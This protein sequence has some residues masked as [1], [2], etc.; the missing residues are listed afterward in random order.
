M[1]NNKLRAKSLALLATGISQTFF[2]I[3]A[4]AKI[5][6]EVTLENFQSFEE[7]TED[8]VD[9]LLRNGASMLDHDLDGLLNQ[10]VFPHEDE[11]E[12]QDLEVQTDPV[13][14]A[15]QQGNL[16]AIMEL[17]VEDHSVIKKRDKKYRTPLI[18]AFQVNTEFALVLFDRIMQECAPN[19]VS[20]M[21]SS[22]DKD[23]RNVMH[24]VA[25]VDSLVDFAH[26]LLGISQGQLLLVKDH[27]GRTPLHYAVEANAPSML[28]FLC[29]VSKCNLISSVDRNGRTPLHY[30]ASNDKAQIFD[31]L[32]KFGAEDSEEV[33]A[34]RLKARDKDGATPIH[35][36]AMNN[37][38][39][40]LMYLWD[41]NFRGGELF[42]SKDANKKTPLHYAA[43][44]KADDA[45]SFLLEK[46]SE[47]NVFPLELDG[48]NHSPLHFAIKSDDVEAVKRFVSLIVGKDFDPAHSLDNNGMTILHYAVKHGAFNVILELLRLF[49]A[50]GVNDINAIEDQKGRNIF[51]YVKDQDMVKTPDGEIPLAVWLINNGVINPMHRDS[52]GR[53][54]LH[55]AVFGG[56][57]QIVNYLISNGM[58]I[59]LTDSEGRTP[60]F[61][62]L[63]ANDEDMIKLFLDHCDKTTL[64][65][66]TVDGK[67]LLFYAVDNCSQS[68]V[69]FLVEGGVSASPERKN[70]DSMNL[71]HYS[72]YHGKLDTTGYLLEYW[73]KFCG[74]NKEAYLN[75]INARDSKG[76]TPLLYASQNDYPALVGLLVSNGAR[77]DIRDGQGRNCL[78]YAAKSGSHELV[79]LFLEV[80]KNLNG[81]DAKGKTPLHYAEDAGIVK[82]LLEAGADPNEI[83]NNGRT[84]LF[85]AIEEDRLD[86][87]IFLI[88]ACKVDVGH[89]DLKNNTPIFIAAKSGSLL[90]VKLL[91]DAGATLDIENDDGYTPEE[92]AEQYGN[93]D[94]LDYFKHIRSE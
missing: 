14:V 73:K 23:G 85:D 92:L 46:F 25:Q 13:F 69:Q 78:H 66:N 61:Y 17:I 2:P 12:D 65:T 94:V 30:A 9:V 49:S 40:V 75:A 57:M 80:D 43:Q 36:A 81:K 90:S 70:G 56:K 67:N 15:I 6:D 60:F 87:V 37:S 82:L 72:A 11:N 26:C 24:L 33:I 16:D 74:E 10:E 50:N 48:K 47:L 21:L 51:F 84:P 63:K 89:E 42:K 91:L 38:I 22:V 31:M 79:K 3:I 53:Y 83:D 64:D 52:K 76:V 8:V 71:L 59:S 58:P 1:K 27:N 7:D 32:L 44:G 28:F 86:V 29:E 34:S 88:A 93:R 45:I 68:L 35:C 4:S 39:G 77:Y 41:L 55:Y 20:D 19:E 62:A 5:P 18:F 54:I